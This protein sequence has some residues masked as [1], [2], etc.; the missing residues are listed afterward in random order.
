MAKSCY[1]SLSKASADK[2]V[3]NISQLLNSLGSQLP[4]L[5]VYDPSS[6][7]CHGTS[8]NITCHSH[9]YEESLYRDT[10]HLNQRGAMLVLH[11]YFKWYVSKSSNA[12]LMRR[13]TLAK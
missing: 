6:S 12:Y 8:A 3:S 5:L 7:I 2:S 4:N 1:Q 11:D 9:L 13:L 10:S